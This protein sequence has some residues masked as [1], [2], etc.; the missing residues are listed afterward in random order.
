MTRS[1]SRWDIGVIIALGVGYFVAAKLGLR[2]AFV[3]P[4]AT[5]VWPPTGIALAALVLLGLRA[6]PAIFFGALLANLTTAGSVATSLA[7][8][9]G[10]ALE[11]VVGAYLVTRF[12]GGPKTFDRAGNVF[13]F[14][15]CAAIVST[16]VSATSGV[17]TL[18]LGGFARWADYG[19]IW[20]TWW[21]GDA[22]GDLVV[23]PALLLWIVAPRVQ[24]LRHR[25]LEG[26]ALA[27]ATTLS[28]VVVFGGS[29]TLSAHNYPV[30][31][32]CIPVLLWAAV[33]FDQ[34]VS[35][36]AIL[37]LSG[38][39][40]WG[41]LHGAGPF[42]RPSPN[43]SLLLLQAFLAVT[44]VMTLT[45]G[46][47][48]TEH[49]RADAE[50]RQLATSDPLTGLANYRQLIA[51][52]DAELK[53]SQRTGRPFA[54]VMLDVDGLKR[55]NDRHGHL[56]GSRALYRV[57]D[58]LR[59][60]CREIDTAGRYGG[61]E[62][63]LILPETDADA[64]HDV[65]RR[66]AERLASDGEAPAISVSTGVAVY[67]QEGDTIEQLFRAA[68]EALYARKGKGGRRIRPAV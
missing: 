53:R 44:A 16:A 45:L 58:A 2:L 7:I 47:A 15:L 66:V 46:A 68:D 28:A 3:N 1:R 55:I 24:W 25:A 60:S 40:V 38:I 21:L 57:A 4:S 27:L 56:T 29:L 61:D 43:E 11:A 67:P 65:A 14:V 36:A 39:A 5:A 33:R 8:A 18:A 19:W 17:T 12:A 22:A 51:A 26:A 13:K 35:A 31:F 10:N 48:V 52:V 54:V 42:S 9:G 20:L 34:R 23:A 62:F 49:R 6:W 37:L 41:T 59:G 32:L 50:L 64:A 63:A 30:A